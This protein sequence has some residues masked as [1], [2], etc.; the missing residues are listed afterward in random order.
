[1]GQILAENPKKGLK[2]ARNG[3][4]KA[5]K[6]KFSKIG[7]VLPSIFIRSSQKLKKNQF[8]VP[9]GSGNLPKCDF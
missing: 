2:L 7:S 5:P 3:L 8:G 6:L 9:S 4:K 1:M